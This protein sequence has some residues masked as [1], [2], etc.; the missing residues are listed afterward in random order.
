MTSPEVQEHAI[1]EYCAARGHVLLEPLVYG[2][3]ESGSRAKSS[4]W[5]KLDEVVA[6][7]ET[8]DVDGA[9]VWKFSRVARHRLRWAIA[10]D[11]VE[12]VGGVLESATEQFDTTTSAGRF[13]RGMTAEMN[14]FQAEM[15]GDSWREAH[16]RRVRSGR[17][18]GGRGKWGYRYDK[19]QG[20]Y[21]PDPVTGPALAEAYRRYV[22]GE[23]VYALARWLNSRGLKTLAGGDWSDRTL[24]RVLDSGFAAG[25]F[26]YRGEL[27]QGVHEPL[28]DP[29]LWQAYL[30]ARE[31]RR[32][33]PARVERSTYPL[34][35]LVRCARCGG[36]MVANVADPGTKLAS[37]GKRYSNGRPRAT[38][39]CSRGKERGPEACR[40]GYVTMRL[41]EEHVREYLA[42]VATAVDESA[43][44][45]SVRL[46][47]REVAAAEEQRLAREA[48]RV[49]EALIKLATDNALSPMPTGIYTEARSRLERRAAELE[50]AAA[51]AGRTSRQGAADRA[52]AAAGLLEQWDEVPAAQMREILRG[53]IDCVLVRTGVET[54]WMRVVDWDEIRA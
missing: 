45:Q 30:D 27:H 12:S 43:D 31:T 22:A 50:A 8:G 15:I 48:G 51:V 26:A 33:L 41:V 53:L 16:E 19:E 52:A 6:E 39:R 4:W 2:L 47:R 32:R 24:R 44:S 20:I 23:S 18:H 14:A 5:R 13:A 29:A 3:D 54:R 49:R 38:F 7:I 10:V 40:G 42:V 37:N 25:W 11:R 35:G 9:V 17:P 28:I 46:A 21:L 1:R 34:S 36:A